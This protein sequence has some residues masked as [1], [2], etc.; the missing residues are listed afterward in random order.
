M[1]LDVGITYRKPTIKSLKIHWVLEGNFSTGPKSLGNLERSNRQR[2][3]TE[4]Y[5][6]Q[7]ESR[8][9]F[10]LKNIKIVFKTSF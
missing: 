7:D 10:Q 9:I 6:L 8:K 1:G 4:N 5:L 2:N 3:H